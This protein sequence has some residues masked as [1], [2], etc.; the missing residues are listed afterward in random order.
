M[1]LE[2]EAAAMSE[3]TIADFI[4]VGGLREVVEC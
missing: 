3:A 2:A 1:S 4:F